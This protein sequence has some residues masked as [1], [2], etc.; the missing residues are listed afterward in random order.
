[1]SKRIVWLADLVG[2]Y[3][4][5]RGCTVALEGGQMGR[6]RRRIAAY[7]PSAGARGFRTLCCRHRWVPFT[8]D[9][10]LC[11]AEAENGD[12]ARMAQIRFTCNTAKRS[13]NMYECIHRPLH[14]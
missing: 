13:G 5:K 9:I 6:G 12:R 7:A 14:I 10:E 1:M 11:T 4:Y 3:G 2:V 8:C